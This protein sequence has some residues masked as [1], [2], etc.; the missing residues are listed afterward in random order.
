MLIKTADQIEEYLTVMLTTVKSGRASNQ[1]MRQILT[2]SKT[3]TSK[4]A[5]LQTVTAATLA[6]SESHGD[7]GAGMLCNSIGISKHKARKQIRTAETLGS[8][9]VV[10]EALEEGKIT[11][12][13]ADALAQASRKT[14]PEAVQADGEL[15]KQAQVM[16]EDQFIKQTRVW[17]MQHQHD[18]GETDHKRMRS[19]RYLRIWNGDDGMTHLYGQFDPTTGA[20]IRSRLDHT[21]LKLYKQDKKRQ[22]QAAQPNTTTTSHHKTNNSLT[23]HNNDSGQT[24][25]GNNTDVRSFEQCRA[26]AFEQL[27]TSNR[28][29]SNTRKENTVDNSDSNS[30]VSSPTAEILVYADLTALETNNHH[31]TETNPANT[32]SATSREDWCKRK[33]T[34]LTR[35]VTNRQGIAEIAGGNP[36][37]PSVL[38]RL[39]CNARITGL[40]F[41]GPGRPL[42]CGRT[43]RTVN[44]AQLKALQLR[45]KSC[46][47]CGAHPSICQAH[48][49]V[50]WSQGGTTDL[51][52]LALV[53]YQCHHKI[54]DNSWQITTHNGKLHLQ[55][56]NPHNNTN[57]HTPTKHT[58]PKP[59]T[60]RH[61]LAQ[62]SKHTTPSKLEPS[63][64][65]QMSPS[66]SKFKDATHAASKYGL[67]QT[68][69]Q[70]QLTLTQ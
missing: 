34:P 65:S 19:Q 12:T 45:D 10:R 24:N 14:D 54:H 37:P 25:G 55:P 62:R 20:R 40:L 16:P 27:F 30:G 15:L 3:I 63:Q 32:S 7:G 21:A 67:Q 56:P 49:I 22:R 47:G 35:N 5:V 4:L 33:K 48:H 31:H 42:W 57:H 53:C 29:N 1:E 69:S 61:Q 41:N 36:I 46:I 6:R 2:K 43:R 70:P 39:M 13:N 23:Y 64:A 44:S 68:A 26:D 59:N 52:N 11:F 18:R 58:H 9:P 50:P 51:D 17:T 28:H 60:T 38:E 8:L 66:L